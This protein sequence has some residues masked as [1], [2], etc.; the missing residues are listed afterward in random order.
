MNDKA[1]RGSPFR[2]ATRWRVS[3]LAAAVAALSCGNTAW[4]Q[5]LPVAAPAALPAAFGEAQSVVVTGSRIRSIDATS[6]SPVTSVGA[7]EFTQRGVLRVEDLINTLPQAYADQSGGGNRG[8]TV[9]ASGTATI[10]LRNLGSQR[11]L[12]L[13]D[14][15]RLMQG[16][17]A[18]SA[19]QAPD[20]NNIPPALIE[21]VDVVTGGASAVY[22][23]DALAGVVNFIMKRNFEGLRF[24]VQ[25]SAFQ[26][27][28]GNVIGA[29]AQAAGQPVP[30]GSTWGGGQQ[31]A[32]LTFGQNF[33]GG[34]GNFT[35]YVG[36]RNIEGVGTSERDFMTCNLSA[37]ATGY[38]CALSSTTY[39]GQFQLTNPATG[40]VRATVALDP[41]TGNTFR[42]Y[43]TSDGFNNGNTYDLQAPT[44]RT[45]ANLFA[46]YRLSDAVQLYGEFGAMRNQADIRLSPTGVFTVAQTVPCANPLLSA[47]Q[48]I[49][50]CSSVGL[51]AVQ[52]AR[53]IVS[54]RNALGGS[55]HD[56]TT[57]NSL[58]TV[59]GV[60]GDLASGWQYDVYAQ[61]GRTLYDSSLNNEISLTRFAR[62]LT[63]VADGAGKPACRSAVN[64][65]DPNCVPFN[66]WQ[67]GAVSPAALD[68]VG[69]T[70]KR[71]GSLRQGI[72]SGSLTGD[73]GFKSPWALQPAALAVGAE[74][75]DE[76]ISFTPDS[77]YQTRDTAGN[78]G[79]EFPINGSFNVKEVFAEMRLQIAENKPWARSLALEAGYR[80]SSYSTAGATDAFKLASE[81]APDREF[82]LRGGLQRAVR[83]PYLSELFGPQRVTSAAISDPCE[84]TAPRATATQCAG[85]GVTA[86][87]YGSIA[88]AAGQQS[89]A[90]VGGN[91][92][93]VPEISNTFTAG[94]Q[95]TP[96]SLAVWTFSADYFKI[97][98]DK[99]IGTV[100]AGIT[101]NQCITAGAFCSLIN[102][103][104]TTGSLVTSGY[105]VTT[106][107]NSG[108][109]KTSGFDFAVNGNMPLA[110]V[111]PGLG[112]KLGIN[113]SSTF[114]SSYEV[115]ILPGTQP[116]RCDGYFGVNCGVPLPKWRHRVSAN[117]AAPSGLGLV[118]TW[119]Y[120]GATANDKSNPADFLK[121]SYQGYDGV[122]TARS[123]VDLGAS[124]DVS[125][126]LTLRVGVN[127][128]ADRDPPLTASTGGAVASG[129]VYTGMYDVLGRQYFAGAT[130]KF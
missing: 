69:S 28:N 115:Q 121:A 67:I 9:G 99:L 37:T 72:V 44:K 127:N 43:R 126:R 112:G 104:G 111:A 18:R 96:S 52:D 128:V 84:G 29:V 51:T 34:R 27:N 7:L 21:R 98:V 113:A 17:P 47:Q 76:R 31:A 36:H 19:A 30:Q 25:G 123:Y 130:L 74:F 60:R 78:S 40:L 82:R 71:T 83:A 10:N 120:V 6:I 22:G 124:F 119:R 81:W 41:T 8:G 103:N 32:S 94:L 89:G 56:T 129:P 70:V 108:Y 65:T 55:R 91:P 86:A 102:R 88:P 49:Q 14:G 42:T 79:G 59:A 62:A 93:L 73:L 1:M 3:S 117:W 11:T 100:P 57:H 63:V 68:Y 106:S 33:A 75:R 2:A 77:N 125:K 5:A 118:A 13:I 105:V 95:F 54:Y 61:L 45:N 24:D 122:L 109:L 110:S 38:G 114:L 53:T 48:I 20:I 64:G 97:K 90:L 107:I 26:H 15:R 46:Q 50:L 16:D 116:Y 101:L 80:H 39:P 92:N 66:I 85:S 58:R 4:A 23:S 12:V 87:Q 35:A